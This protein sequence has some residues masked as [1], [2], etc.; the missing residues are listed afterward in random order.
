MKRLRWALTAAVASAMVVSGA[1]SAHWSG[2]GEGAG[3]AETAQS[4]PIT[5][6]PGMP[7]D[8]LF[9]GDSGA[10]A[11]L[12]SNPNAYDVHLGQLELDP[13]AGSGGYGVDVGHPACPASVLTYTS[14]SN[15]GSGWTVPAASGGLDGTVSINLTNALHMAG[16]APDACQGA[17]FVVHL[18]P[19]P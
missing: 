3:S 6:S 1:A 17:T 18:A 16:N 9:P 8:S 2:A 10:V 15:Q 19:I 5:L 12:A 13:A 14:Q 11:V 7:S 4:M